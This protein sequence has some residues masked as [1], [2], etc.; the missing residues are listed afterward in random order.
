L[1]RKAIMTSAQI[2]NSVG[3]G[4]D[5][6]G[7]ILVWKYALPNRVQKEDVWKT[8]P[9]EKKEKNFN[10]LDNIGIVLILLGFLYQLISNWL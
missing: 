8:D 3:L 10:I 5:I 7:V 6:L 4:F 2:A 9:Y 1:K